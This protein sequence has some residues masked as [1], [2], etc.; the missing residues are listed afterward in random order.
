MDV[1][2]LVP[3]RGPV[4]LMAA[5]EGLARVNAPFAPSAPNLYRAG[6]RYRA[7]L[8]R[9]EDWLSIPLVIQKRFADCEDLAAYRVAV[10]RAQGIDAQFRL[11]KRGNVWHVTLVLPNGQIED[12]SRRLG[13]GRE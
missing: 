3:V 8:P 6:V 1:R 4:Q 2:I 10:L 11:T 7:E 12:P 9:K 13:M 5:C